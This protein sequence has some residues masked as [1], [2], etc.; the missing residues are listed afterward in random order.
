MRAEHFTCAAG[1][2]YPDEMRLAFL[3]FVLLTMVAAPVAAAWPDACAHDAPATAMSG[4]RDA[5]GAMPMH[6]DVGVE[7]PCACDADCAEHCDAV[8]PAALLGVDSPEQPVA[9]A[10]DGT[11]VAASF[12]AGPPRTAPLRPPQTR[13]R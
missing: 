3:V 1:F 8:A 4:D 13:S 6:H 11:L 7:A 10:S 2:D 9:V 12:H 5:H